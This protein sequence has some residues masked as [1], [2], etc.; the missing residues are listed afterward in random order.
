M[1]W[2]LLRAALVCGTFV[3]TPAV[4][5]AADQAVVWINVVNAT[6]SG[7]VLQKT[8][9][10][11]GCDDAGATSQQELPS[12][13]GYIEFTVGEMNTFL[14]AG[15]S[16]GNTDTTLADID[17][18]FRF[19]GAGWA[20]VLENG[21]YQLGGDTPYAAGDVFR[22]AVSGNKVHYIR[23]G[24]LILESRKAPQYPLLLDASLGTMGATVRNARLGVSDPSQSD[25]GFI[26]KA[27]SPATRAR[28]TRSQIESFLPP[29][30]AKGAFTFPPPY[31]TQGVRLT[32]ATD[33]ANGQDC[34]WYVGYSY[35]RN[36]NNHVGSP[37]MLILLG[38]DRNRGGAGPTLIGYNKQTDE[39]ENLGPL[40]TP[41]N[42]Y[43]YSTAE[44]WYFSGLQP[45]KLYTYL[46]GGSQLRR[47]DVITKQFDTTPALDLNECRRPRV[48]PS[49]AA[50]I[51][52]PHSSDDD[53]VHSATVQDVNF[54]SLGCV[55]L[56]RKRFSYFATP[57]GHV[58]DECHVDKS[59]RW[60]M[61][62]ETKP[63]GS[64]I[65]RIADLEKGTTVTIEDTEG[66]L[67]HLDMG[68]GYAVG[69]DNYNSRANATILVKFPVTSTHRPVGPV[70]HFNKGWDI[71]AANHV[72]HGNASAGIPV[73]NQFACG[74]NASRVIDMADEIVCFRL[75]P[76]H[77]PDGSLDVLVIGQVMTDLDARGGGDTDGD[78]YE[79]LP[80]GNLDITGSYFIWTT[81]MGGDRLDV[82]LVKIPKF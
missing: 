26:E 33:C 62:L 74:S 54:R 46:V 82:F 24:A 47:F 70:V 48:C 25:G 1:P 66:S 8:T 40:F 21:V 81:N 43:S 68:H 10:C 18:A 65:N 15:L 7:D 71:A 37:I 30:G 61:I 2:K 73:E 63:D 16:N 80:K 45:T 44:G 59:G 77:N 76:N 31:N 49:S 13:D 4:G 41:D 50:Y 35:W 32:N 55:V 52:Q 51:F 27:G 69:A 6:V 14:V 28:F 12:G 56:H 34:V 78:D 22:I 11:D 19:N 75:D 36:S 42:I 79:Q 17:F 72:A 20:D 5:D 53:L 58:F 64:S 39:V 23:N 67:G 38:M 9:G 57:P 29:N 3:C 60:L